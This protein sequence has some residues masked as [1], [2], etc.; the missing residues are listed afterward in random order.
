MRLHDRTP[1]DE[2]TPADEIYNTRDD[3]NRNATVPVPNAR[4]VTTLHNKAYAVSLEGWLYN[5]VGGEIDWL[6]AFDNL[7]NLYREL[8]N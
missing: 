5:Y 6:D 8:K 2:Y 7:S 3:L 1:A 4:H